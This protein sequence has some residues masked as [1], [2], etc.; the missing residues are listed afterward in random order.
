MNIV[1]IVPINKINKVPA[2]AHPSEVEL[3]DVLAAELEV[4]ELLVVEP[5]DVKLAGTKL[6]AFLSES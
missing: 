3:L 2:F 4:L 6:V 5:D 1:A